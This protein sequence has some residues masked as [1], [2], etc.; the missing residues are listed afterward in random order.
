M[1]NLSDVSAIE[2]LISGVPGTK[3]DVAAMLSHRNLARQ[4]D[5]DSA[6]TSSP[7]HQVQPTTKI[8]MRRVSEGALVLTPSPRRPPVIRHFEGEQQY[9]GTVIAINLRDRNFTARLASVNGNAPDEE[10]EFSLDELNGDENLVVPGALFTWTIGLQ[11]RGQK[12]QQIRVSDIRFRR[13]PPVTKEAIA[14]AENEA[15]ELSA[16]LLRTAIEAPIIATL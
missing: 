3:L 4:L 1:T 6:A 5:S 7:A 11:S 14:K 10:G 16:F 9:E 2:R 13:L 8:P 12:G 15:E